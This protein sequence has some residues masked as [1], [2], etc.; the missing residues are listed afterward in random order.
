MLLKGHTDI[1]SLE[2][3]ERG[4]GLKVSKFALF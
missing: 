2:K 4:L 3:W 1:A